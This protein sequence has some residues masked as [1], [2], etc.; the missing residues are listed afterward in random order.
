VISGQARRELQGAAAHPYR[1][2]PPPP[3]HTRFVIIYQQKYLL[4]TPVKGL[5]RLDIFAPEDV[6]LNGPL[7][8]LPYCNVT[9]TANQSSTYRTATM[10]APWR[11]LSCQ[12]CGAPAPCRGASREVSLA[13]WPH[14]SGLLG[15]P[16]SAGLAG[17]TRG[18]SGSTRAADPSPPRP[19]LL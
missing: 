8:D 10:P 12:R 15:M 17:A 11:Q 19:Q 5:T 18:C 7:T 2:F 6:L 4:Y 13:Q 1:P 14:N 16:H 3:T 9:I